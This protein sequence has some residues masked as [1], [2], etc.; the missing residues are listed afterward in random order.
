MGWIISEVGREWNAIEDDSQALPELL[1]LSQIINP[2]FFCY[3]QP[4]SPLEVT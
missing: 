4:Q 2:N 1:P 3:M